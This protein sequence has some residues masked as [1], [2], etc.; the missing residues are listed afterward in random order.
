[1]RPPRSR[2]FTLLEMLV[3]LAIIGVTASLALTSWRS[4]MRTR[5][6]VLSLKILS[7]A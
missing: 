5:G 2:T 3:V 7:F 4:S 1:M 6:S